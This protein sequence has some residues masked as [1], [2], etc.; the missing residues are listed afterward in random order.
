MSPENKHHIFVE[1]AGGKV[2]DAKMLTLAEVSGDG[3]E[4][5]PRNTNHNLSSDWVRDPD[6]RQKLRDEL[7]DR[8]SMG[9]LV[10]FVS[11]VAYSSEKQIEPL[12]GHAAASP[13]SNA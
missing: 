13:S 8:W 7:C 10:A 12:F 2:R 5:D 1:L 3:W 6:T 11:V 4:L 9:Q